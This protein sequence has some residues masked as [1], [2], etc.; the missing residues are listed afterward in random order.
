M[1]SPFVLVTASCTVADVLA[2]YPATTPIFNLLGLDSCCGTRLTLSQ[3]AEHARTDLG[4]LLSML[5]AAACASL[6]GARR[7]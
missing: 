1:S 7:D 3:A 6:A 4:V 5:E 2:R